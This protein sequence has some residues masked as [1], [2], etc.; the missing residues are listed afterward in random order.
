MPENV[1][2][3]VPV[4]VIKPS[5]RQLLSNAIAYMD[6]DSSDSTTNGS[7]I[8]MTLANDSAY[9]PAML[10]YGILYANATKAFP[11]VQTRQEKLGVVP[12]LAESNDWLQKVLE[13]EPTNYKAAYW[14]YN[15]LM[16]KVM[17][18]AAT[19]ED[20]ALMASTFKLFKKTVES[21][22]DE[23]AARY[24]NAMIAAGDE[25]T[26]KAWAVIN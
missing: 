2:D 22:T 6:V 17:N 14:L 4:P 26:L 15:N 10:E 5:S 8:L 20:L 13:K 18:N 21:S 1:Q 9:T 25:D 24:K 11:E 7:K 3:S 12:N 16:T 19:S 23:D